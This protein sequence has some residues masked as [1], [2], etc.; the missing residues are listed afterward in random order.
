MKILI[1]GLG[2]IGQRHVQTMEKVIN[3]QFIYFPSEAPAREV[4][5][6]QK[7]RICVFQTLDECVRQRPDFAIIANATPGHISIAKVM[8]ENHIPFIIEK[9]VAISLTNLDD[10]CE[11]IDQ[12]QLQVLVGFQLRH[13]PTFNLLQKI[14]DSGQIGTPLLFHGYVGQY[15]PNWRPQKDYKKTVSAS[16]SLGGGVLADICHEFDIAVA[17]LG[18]VSTISAD[19]DR[20]SD[21]AIDTEDIA[22]LS[23][24]HSNRC[25]TNIHLNYLDRK[26]TWQTRLVGSEGTI[27]WDYTKG[28]LELTLSG[29]ESTEIIY[30]PPDFSREQLFERQAKHWL[31]VLSGVETSL[32]SFEDGCEI[33]KLIVAADESSKNRTP[34]TL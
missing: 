12:Q 7:H 17:L 16:K 14:V 15:L 19:L 13:H 10:L 26:F 2:S 29:Q 3:A 23:L 6:I 25:H 11:K 1:V 31:D 22:N 20:L 32:V 34:V 28:F 8:V 21:L 5:F 4:D 27:L 18:P 24:V 9:P 30:D 33:T